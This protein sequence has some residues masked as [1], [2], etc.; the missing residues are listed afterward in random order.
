MSFE[1][2]G[3][4]MKARLKDADEFNTLIFEK[5]YSKRSFAHK[6]KI[7]EATMI[8]ISNGDRLAGP[9]VAKKIIDALQVPFD[10]IFEIIKTPKPTK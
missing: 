8:Q 5:G 9:R 10:D 4:E 7:G 3:D 2:R 1:I 6:A